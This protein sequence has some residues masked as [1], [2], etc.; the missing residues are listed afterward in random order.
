MGKQIEGKLD[1]KGLK[2]G[3]IVSRFNELI[4]KGLLD[5]AVDCLKRHG[6][7]DAN[8]DSAWVPGAFEMPLVAKKMAKNL[9]DL[10][11]DMY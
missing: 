8:I 6:A 1:E 2:F 5:G 10:L 3:I 7:T 11:K 9:Q 4:S